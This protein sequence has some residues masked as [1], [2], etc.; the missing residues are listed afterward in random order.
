MKAIDYKK[1]S[2]KPFQILIEQMLVSKK[3]D[4]ADL[5]VKLNEINPLLDLETS[6][7]RGKTFFNV[8][9]KSSLD[10]KDVIERFFVDIPS[11]KLGSFESSENALE[12]LFGSFFNSKS[13][14]VN[15]SGIKETRLNELFKN[16][17][18]SIYSYEVFALAISF[19]LE[20]VIL[21]EY[22]Y[23]NGQRPVVGSKEESNT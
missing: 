6:R 21:F 23:S 4:K 11:T 15:A 17:F 10:L 9:K 3:L 14:L 2:V 13:D 8:V 18:E 20:P 7:L 16:K 1:Y 19:G 22:F 5:D 12:D